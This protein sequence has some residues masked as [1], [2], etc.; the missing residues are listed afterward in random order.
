MC[1]ISSSRRARNFTHDDK[2]ILTSNRC[3]RFGELFDGLGE[4]LGLARQS[5]EELT[6]KLA[7]LD[8]R[9]ADLGGDDVRSSR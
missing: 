5:V 9:N 3:Q 1:K 4:F 8:R 7:K 2:V 6:K